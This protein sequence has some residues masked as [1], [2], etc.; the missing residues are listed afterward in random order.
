[1]LSNHIH[2][3]RIVTGCSLVAAAA[4][5]LTSC[6][7]VKEDDR[8]IKIER[9]EVARKVLVQ[10]FTGINCVNCP[11]G[12]ATIHDLQELYPGSIIAVGLHPG[13]TGFSGPIGTFNLNN[14]LATTYF[15]YY[16]PA[17]FPAAVID[18]QAPITNITAWNGSIMSQI[19]K[20]AAGEIELTPT[21]DADTR[22]VTV[23]YEVTLNSVFTSTLNINIWVVENGIRGPQKSGNTI[24][25]TYE[26]N[27]VLRGSLTGDWGIALNSTFL[28]DEV[29]T[30][31]VSLTLDA[32][33]VAENCQL[34][35]FLQS[36]SKE[37]H[38]AM[39]TS[40]IPDSESDTED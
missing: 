1:M 8:L 9:P 2:F 20:A 7:D 29:Y 22:T 15:N 38:Q 6:D 36:D 24:I 26:H 3:S 19:S 5:A 17:G 31:T 23:D 30:G 34:V 35:A 11:T 10:E 12:A 39:E 32:A 33:W 16:N 14:E 25:P 37:V 4:M 27:H 40:L 21:Y 18:G 13:G 28:P